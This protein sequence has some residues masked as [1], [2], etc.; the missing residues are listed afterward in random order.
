MFKKISQK[1]GLFLTMLFVSVGAF[2]QQASI[3]VAPMVTE[4]NGS[5]APLI[6]IG[7]AIVGVSVVILI[8]RMIKRL[9]G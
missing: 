5:R 2:A 7:T 4:I 3:D 9:I 8:V 1:V 6:A